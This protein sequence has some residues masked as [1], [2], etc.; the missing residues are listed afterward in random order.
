MKDVKHDGSDQLNRL[1]PVRVPDGYP[2]PPFPL[3]SMPLF[4]L[5][6]YFLMPILSFPL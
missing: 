5:F 6:L 2:F 3:F 1:G 4:L